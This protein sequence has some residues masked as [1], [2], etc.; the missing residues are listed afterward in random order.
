M[1][2]FVDYITGLLYY[3]PYYVYVLAYTVVCSD[4]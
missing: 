1:P 3:D 4:V 2:F